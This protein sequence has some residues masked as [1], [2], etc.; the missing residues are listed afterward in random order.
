MKTKA[1]VIFKTLA[2]NE[3]VVA[4]AQNREA[5]TVNVDAVEE[6]MA[7]M[8]ELTGGTDVE[9]NNTFRQLCKDRVFYAFEPIAGNLMDFDE[10]PVVPTVVE[11]VLLSDD[12][13]AMNIN[14]NV[15]LMYP[16]E[17]NTMYATKAEAEAAAKEDALKY[18][19]EVLEMLTSKR[20]QLKSELKKLNDQID[21]HLNFKHANA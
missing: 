16:E 20:R 17:D 2:S 15:V 13:V 1:I 10:G 5:L 11:C 8:K 14:G 21:M 9:F 6:Y 7:K 12:R 3:Q 18:N 19:N 4:L